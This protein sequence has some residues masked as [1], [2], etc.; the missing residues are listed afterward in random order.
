M[1]T[2]ARIADLIR[3]RQPD[4][5][6]DAIADGAFYEMQT[7]SAALI[8]LVLQDLVDHETAANAATNRH[9]FEIALEHALKLRDVTTASRAAERGE[10]PAPE[11]EQQEPPPLRLAAS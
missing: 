5:I 8:D 2:N 4:Q 10:P 11:S 1:V 3:E 7:F 9:D 6:T